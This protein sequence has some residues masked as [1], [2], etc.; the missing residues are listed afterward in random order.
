MYK[1]YRGRLHSSSEMDTKWIFF[2]NTDFLSSLQW[3]KALML[4]LFG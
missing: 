2:P 3:A 4:Q 1:W